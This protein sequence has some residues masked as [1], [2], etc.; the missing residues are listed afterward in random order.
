M[1]QLLVVSVLSIGLYSIS[2]TTRYAEKIFPK[3]IVKPET[4]AAVAVE[5]AGC[6]PAWAGLSRRKFAKSC[7][8]L[9]G[10]FSAVY[11]PIFVTKCLV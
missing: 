8:R 9:D 5:K 10:S 4:A 7:P 11:K 6:S 3:G 1:E 2:A